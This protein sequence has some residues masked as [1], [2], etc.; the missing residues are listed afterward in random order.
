MKEIIIGFL[1]GIVSGLGMGGGTILILFLTLFANVEQHIAQA[2]NVTFF[3]PTA[4]AAIIIFIK[5]KKIKFKVALPIC[6]FGIIGAILG[7]IIS[8]NMEVSMLRKVFSIFLIL[9]AIYELYSFYKRYIK[10]KNRDTS[11]K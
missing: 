3:I 9:V 6:L 11:I 7:A 8:S 5:N 4:I 1:A 10:E 2:S